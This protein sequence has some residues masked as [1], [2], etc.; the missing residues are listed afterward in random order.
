[1]KS[2]NYMKQ[3]YLRTYNSDYCWE[4]CLIYRDGVI[5]MPSEVN[6]HPNRTFLKFLK[7]VKGN[8]YYLYTNNK[9]EQQY[10]E[11]LQVRKP[12]YRIK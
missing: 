11:P 3:T 2:K 8:Y 10:I 12:Y 4:G 9:W 7:K 1:M 6:F 5:Q